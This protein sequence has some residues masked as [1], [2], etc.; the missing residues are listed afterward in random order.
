MRLF[1]G[2]QSIG[3][4]LASL[5]VT[6]VFMSALAA[7]GVTIMFAMRELEAQRNKLTT[8]HLNVLAGK[9]EEVIEYAADLPMSIKEVYAF[10]SLVSSDLS[11]PE[12]MKHSRSARLEHLSE[13]LESQILQIPLLSEISL[14]SAAL[15]G[16][17]ILHVRWVDGRATAFE[18]DTLGSAPSIPYFLQTVRREGKPTFRTPQSGWSKTALDR[19]SISVGISITGDMKHHGAVLVVRCDISDWLRESFRP[20]SAGEQVFIADNSGRILYR[21][22]GSRSDI[23]PD[24]TIRDLWAPGIPSDL[25]DLET[26]TTYKHKHSVLALRPFVID[27]GDERS[28]Q[29]PYIIGLF[30]PS[31][32]SIYANFSFL[33]TT[34]ICTLLIAVLT[35]LW[36][37]YLTNPIRRLSVLAQEIAGG[38]IGLDSLKLQNGS[39]ETKI[40]SEALTTLKQSLEER[41]AK[42]RESALRLNIATDAAGLGI[43]DMNGLSEN[44]DFWSDEMYRLLG[45]SPVETGVV[46]KLHSHMSEEDAKRFRAAKIKAF[47]TGESFRIETKIM[48]RDGTTRWFS[49]VGQPECVNPGH[50]SRIIGTIQDIHELKLAENIKSEFVS[51]VS[52]ELRTPM[53]SIIGSL[54]LI[55]SKRFGELPDQVA[56]LLGIAEGNANRLLRLINEILDL[57]KMLKSRTQL[58]RE[59]FSIAALLKV[60]VEQN[61]QFCLDNGIELVADGPLPE[62]ALQADFDRLIQVLTNLISNAAKFSPAGSQVAIRVRSEPD[63]IVITIADQGPGI[64]EEMQTRI[65]DPFVQVDSSDTRSAGGTGLGLTIARSIVQLHDGDLWF[66][67]GPGGTQFHIKL[68]KSDM[69]VTTIP[70]DAVITSD[71]RVLLLENDA[72]LANLLQEYLD[73]SIT[74]IHVPDIARARRQMEETDFDHFIVDL[75]LPGERGERLIEDLLKKGVPPS[76][77]LI[78]TAELD[79]HYP[80]PCDIRTFTKSSCSLEELAQHLRQSLMKQI[81]AL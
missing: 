4:H 9:F 76:R 46:T 34:G 73:S 68:P 75:K 51:I 22:T 36:V 3:S 66:E 59:I 47:D 7:S 69:D 67:S 24:L 1:S 49:V 77:I 38:R 81:G 71:C 40:L 39:T 48:C 17:E 8:G 72:D 25:E 20:Q 32:P 44:P 2:S 54:T 37:R 31:E 12:L 80:Y 28:M 29:A 42:L 35:G 21:S 41:S 70:Q 15:G 52:H 43:W 74:L 62:I 57:E 5:V 16:R 64:P 65:F 11:A 26:L 23:Y 33:S 79:N 50:V 56:R 58:N 18:A 78:Y 61:S 14:L 45:Y 27:P 30:A 10:E 13:V 19:F 53:T 6:V 55:N 63:H 60:A